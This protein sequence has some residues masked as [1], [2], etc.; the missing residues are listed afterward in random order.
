VIAVPVAACRRQRGRLRA[1]RDRDPRP[2]SCLARARCGPSAPGASRAWEPQ[3]GGR[4]RL[5]GVRRVAAVMRR[6]LPRQARA[7]ARR[8]PAAHGRDER[9]QARMDISATLC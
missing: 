1:Q 6:P 5:G 3:V 4:A 2:R 7:R 9:P 8:S